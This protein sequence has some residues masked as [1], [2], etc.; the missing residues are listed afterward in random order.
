M[1]SLVM[2]RWL[3]DVGVSTFADHLQ[4]LGGAPA[5]HVSLLRRCL[6]SEGEDLSRCVLQGWT[7]ISSCMI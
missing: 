3:E 7:M 2:L 5:G 4:E 6:V 1:H